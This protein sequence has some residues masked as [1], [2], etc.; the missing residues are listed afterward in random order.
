MVAG[1]EIGNLQH[2][3]NAHDTLGP[4]GHQHHAIAV[5]VGEGLCC[6]EASSGD[7]QFHDC[8]RRRGRQGIA[9]MVHFQDRTIHMVA[10]LL[11]P[12]ARLA[13]V[14]KRKA[15]TLLPESQLLV[16]LIAEEANVNV[17]FGK[18]HGLA[19]LLPSPDEGWHPGWSTVF[20]APRRKTKGTRPEIF[21]LYAQDHSLSSTHDIVACPC[22]GALASRVK[23]PS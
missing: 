8:R 19:R 4:V 1:H 10:M 6:G 23:A 15:D 20:S 16:T 21:A 22:K 2:D 3:A 18:F 13:D 9:S 5:G 7:A 11:Y 17:I 12:A 14:I